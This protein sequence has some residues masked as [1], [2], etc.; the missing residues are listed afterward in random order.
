MTVRFAIV[1]VLLVALVSPAPGG[2][3]P[4]VAIYLYSTST[5]TGGTNHLAAPAPGQS[6][7]LYVCFDQFGPGGALW[8]ASWKFLEVGCPQYVDAT[9]LF[10][11]VGGQ[12]LGVPGDGMGMVMNTGPNPAY[13]NA[14][15]VLVLAGIRYRTV[16]DPPD[17]GS[18][19]LIPHESDGRA[20]LD[21]YGSIDE[22]CV[23]S[24]VCNGLSG[25]WYWGVG[26]AADGDCACASSTQRATW[27]AIKGLYR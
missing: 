14:N 8:C 7:T 27:G 22:W 2:L 23:H 9:N 12:T 11:G 6:T 26:V 5:G 1:A 19:T 16:E 3:N 24:T 25:N 10:A 15:G 13:P 20:V 18:I 21:Q 17:Y 4:H